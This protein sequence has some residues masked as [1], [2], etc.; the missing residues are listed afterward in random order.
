M[1]EISLDLQGTRDLVLSHAVTNTGDDFFDEAIKELRNGASESIFEELY[2]KSYA[3]NQKIIDC[4]S[5]SNKLELNDLEYLILIY[6]LQSLERIS[7]YEAKYETDERRIY[8]KQKYFFD[9]INLLRQVKEQGYT[10]GVVTL[11]RVILASKSI[12]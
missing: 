5:C 2:R 12:S 9:S 11:D 1:I 6:S 4:R 7:F 10:P 8:V 3:M